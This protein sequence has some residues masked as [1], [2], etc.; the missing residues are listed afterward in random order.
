MH[1]STPEIKASEKVKGAEYREY[2]N[3]N[4]KDCYEILS[5]SPLRIGPSRTKDSQLAFSTLSVTLKEDVS[6]ARE[7]ELSTLPQNSLNELLHALSNL[8]KAYHLEV[9]VDV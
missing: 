1:S 4:K 3:T 5:E 8:S 9:D 6:G 2:M 7:H